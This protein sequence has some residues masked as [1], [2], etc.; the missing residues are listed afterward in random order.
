LANNAAGK[1]AVKQ[2][3]QAW[4]RIKSEY[5]QLEVRTGVSQIILIQEAKITKLVVY[6]Y[7][8]ICL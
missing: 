5:L 4:M 3:T 1:Q 6:N 7:Y 8:E 2:R